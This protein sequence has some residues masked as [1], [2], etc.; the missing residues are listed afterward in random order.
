MPQ[1]IHPLPTEL[2]EEVVE[3]MQQLQTECCRHGAWVENKGVLLTYHY[4]NIYSRP[5]HTKELI[6]IIIKIIK[7]FIFPRP[8]SIHTV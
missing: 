3:L 2:E 7:I 1:F 4:R 5:F 6:I 8:V